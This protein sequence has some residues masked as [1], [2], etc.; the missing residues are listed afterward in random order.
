[1]LMIS[2]GLA[3]HRDLDVARLLRFAAGHVFGGA[4]DA[5]DAHLGLEQRDGAHGAD[6][7]GAAGHVVLHLFHAVGGLDGDAAGVEGDAFADESEHGR[8]R[9]AGRLVSHH[10]ERGWL[11]RALRNAQKAPIFSSCSLSAP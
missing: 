3:G 1:M 7:R 6:H 9:R 4:D 10:D 5:D 2:I 11:F 8:L